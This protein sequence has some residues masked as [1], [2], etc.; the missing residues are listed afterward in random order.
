M[1]CSRSSR[2]ACLRWS[3]VEPVEH[4]HAVE[5]VDLVQEHAAEQLV[6]LDH[7]LVAVEVEA[8]HGDDLGPHDL[9]REPGQ[10]EAAFLVGPL[11]RSPRRLAG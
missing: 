10:R 4:Q 7:D 1:P 5:V 11:A 9:E 8:L 6:A 3:R 2:I